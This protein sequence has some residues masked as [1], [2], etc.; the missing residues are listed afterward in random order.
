VQS[1]NPVLADLS[2][3]YWDFSGPTSI[4]YILT[5]GSITRRAGDDLFLAG[6]LAAAA[7]GL[8][9]EFLKSIF[10]LHTK[11]VEVREGREHCPKVSR[12]L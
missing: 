5:D 3:L 4:N 1:S 8:A 11:I 12:F 9:V 7:A 6:V 2:S 10:E